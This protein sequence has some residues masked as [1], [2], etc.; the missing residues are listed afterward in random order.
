MPSPRL[1]RCRPLTLSLL[2]P[3]VFVACDSDGGGSTAA[4]C[5]L[6]GAPI[7][8]SH[9]RDFDIAALGDDFVLVVSDDTGV[10]ARVIAADTVRGPDALSLAA[11]PVAMAKGPT[12]LLVQTFSFT[13][14]SGAP[15]LARY[16]GSTWTVGSGTELTSPGFSTRGGTIAAS[17]TESIAFWV[18]GVSQP[19]AMLAPWD[20]PNAGDF[21]PPIEV[22][23]DAADLSGY[24]THA[25]F[26]GTGRLHLATYAAVGGNSGLV[27]S[28]RDVN[29]AWTTAF[30][31][32][33][34][35]Y[36]Q[37]TVTTAMTVDST[38]AVWLAEVHG[39][40]F[41]DDTAG[42]FTAWRD[43][44]T[45][46]TGAR[47]VG[48]F[49]DDRPVAE[50]LALAALDDGRVVATS[51]W[52]ENNFEAAASDDSVMLH[53][54]STGGCQRGATL[55]QRRGVFYEATKVA[56]SG[57]RGVAV[58]AWTKKGPEGA[59]GM[60]VQRFTCDAATP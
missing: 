8:L 2:T 1:A 18:E 29:G 6:Q 48:Q 16:D 3:L 20:A 24:T 21:G 19:K 54:C 43:D 17:A 35:G 46:G 22:M 5:R 41:F 52:G 55:D 12:G 32:A 53:V 31:G 56:A 7:A 27:R 44:G 9:A 26:D 39:A 4:T 14:Q 33:V 58:W 42:G 34:P 57:T 11:G 13:W 36:T 40:D 37:N 50:G 47:K 23:A 60:T 25:A 59:Q 10:N 51:S 49:T 45:G 28:V 15:R 30:I 38:G